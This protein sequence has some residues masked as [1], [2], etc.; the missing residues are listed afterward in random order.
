MTKSENFLSFVQDKNNIKN[1]LVF[2]NGLLG[3]VVF[4]T[5][6][7]S[8]LNHTYP[9]ANIDVIVGRTSVEVLKYFPGIRKIIPFNFDFSILSILKQIGFFTSLIPNKYDLLV[10]PEVNP[11]Y[12]IVGKFCLPKKI[13][14][15]TNPLGFSDY[16]INRPK[17]KATLAEAELVKKWTQVKGNDKAVVFVSDEEKIKIRK[18]LEIFGVSENN[19]ILFFNPGSST[20]Y[21]EKDWAFENYAP[22]ADHFISKLNYKIVFNGLKRD[23]K[24]F[25]KIASIMNCDAIFLAGENAIDIR[26]MFSLISI[27]ELVLGVDTGPIHIATAL[28]IPVLCLTGFTDADE[29]GPYNPN[30]SVTIIK[31]DMP[32]IPCVHSNPKPAQWDICKSM[33]PVECMRRITPQKVILEMEKILNK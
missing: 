19:K 3:D 23:K 6:L 22:V 30:E 11:H 10:V 4:I 17:I 9:K 8:R 1:I 5:S 31:S 13:A 7:L 21:S 27:S 2:R 29:T 33:R 12:T 18:H 16:Q 20:Q 28:D 24:D 15:F 25:E 32:C 14:S 26:S